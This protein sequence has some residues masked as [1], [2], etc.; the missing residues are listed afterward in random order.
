ME[1]LRRKY[2]HTG[3]NPVID[4]DPVEARVVDASPT[5]CERG[6]PQ[7]E[8]RGGGGPQATKIVTGRSGSQAEKSGRKAGVSDTKNTVRRGEEEESE[9]FRRRDSLKRTP[10]SL[11]KVTVPAKKPGYRG[12]TGSAGD[13]AMGDLIGLFED[14]KRKRSP[15]KGDEEEI[16]GDS[17]RTLL[18]QLCEGIHELTTAINLAPNTKRDVVHC[19]SKVSTMAKRVVNHRQFENMPE[20]ETN[21]A[22]KSHKLEEKAKSTR[23]MGTQT[24][25]EPKLEWV[26]RKTPKYSFTNIKEG[27]PLSLD[28]EWNLAVMRNK[29]DKG[30][31]F[32]IQRL[33]RNKY[34]ELADLLGDVAH[35]KTATW[36]MGKEEEPPITR[37][38][39]RVDEGGPEEIEKRL[40]IVLSRLA[41]EGQNKLAL[42]WDD[43]LKSKLEENRDL[44]ERMASENKVTINIHVK[45]RKKDKEREN[46]VKSK[47]DAIFVKKAESRTYA[48]TLTSVRNEVIKKG[49]ADTVRGVRETK[50]GDLILTVVKQS[51][52]GDKEEIKKALQSRFGTDQVRAAKGRTD[53]TVHIK[54]I[55]AIATEQEI[56]EAV[57]KQLGYPNDKDRIKIASLRPAFAGTLSAKVYLPKED[58]QKLLMAQKIKIGLPYCRIAED[59]KVKTCYKCWMPGHSAKTC[60]GPDR[61]KMCRNC[62]KEGHVRLRCTEASCCALCGQAGHPAGTT[63]CPL[64]KK[65]LETKG[66]LG[67]GETPR[68]RRRP[69]VREN[70]TP[71][72]RKGSTGNNGESKEKAREKPII[73]PKP[74]EM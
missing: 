38:V 48:S 55:E 13:V 4:S 5:G 72:A 71:K 49:L 35:I 69:S 9:V 43:Q 65:A 66:S 31:D 40:A 1:G 14:A 36:V 8:S 45:P 19:A 29:E 32:G 60:T 73:S 58:E 54:D 23:E 67:K 42:A 70:K 18:E 50:N 34:G 25:P 24:D 47:T 26:R 59:N 20:L 3:T 61:T 41:K 2:S 44:L 37:L 63:R 57:L 21:R 11:R 46:G 53:G 15:E 12:R 56:R 16:V 6:N 68:G 22:K 52:G 62:G 51:N 17:L 10:P 28:S 74:M 64:Y 39:F 33:F 27:S 7:T 30:M